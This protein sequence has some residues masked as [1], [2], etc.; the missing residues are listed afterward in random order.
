MSAQ[1]AGLILLAIYYTM[2]LIDRRPP[3][4]TS[5]HSRHK[6]PSSGS[7]LL[8]ALA[9]WSQ[10]APLAPLLTRTISASSASGRPT[11]PLPTIYEQRPAA[12]RSVSG[13]TA[14]AVP[15][16]TSSG[17]GYARAHA[18]AHTVRP[19]PSRSSSGLSVR[20]APARVPSG[21]AE[22]ILLDA[23]SPRKRPALKQR[24]SG[25]WES[26]RRVQKPAGQSEALRLERVPGDWTTETISK[27]CKGYGRVSL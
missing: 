15:H 17:S 18:H 3:R 24:D 11:P 10:S 4:P 13:D 12:H 14:R 6:D 20:S 23:P 27:L 2:S 9:R 21:A 8:G 22:E 16:R 7:G 25:S 19:V 1:V 26:Q 5:S